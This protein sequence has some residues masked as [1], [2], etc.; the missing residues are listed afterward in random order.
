[1]GVSALNLLQAKFR[2]KNYI[3]SKNSF[4]IFTCPNPVLH[5]PGFWQLG[6]ALPGNLYTIDINNIHIFV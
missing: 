4:I 5:V 6:L 1:M 2:K 3:Y